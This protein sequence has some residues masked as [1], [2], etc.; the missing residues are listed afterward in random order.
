MI[1]CKNNKTAN[2][3]I[4]LAAHTLAGKKLDE[5]PYSDEEM[6]AVYEYAK[7]AD[8]GGITY[9]AIENA[10]DEEKTFDKESFY[11][12]WKRLRL[13]SYRRNLL[14]D[15]EQKKILNFFDE[16]G[17]WYMPLKGAVIKDFYPSPDLR[18]MNDIDILIDKTKREEINEYM[19][20]IG[21]SKWDHGYHD[22][23]ESVNGEITK[24]EN[25]DDYV[26]KPFYYFEMHKYLIEDSY[27]PYVAK[28][29]DQI[30]DIVVKDEGN[31]CGYHFKDN[32]FYIYLIAHAHKHFSANGIGIRF[33]M[34]VY[35]YLNSHQDLD[36]DYIV[37]FLD[38]AGISGFEKDVRDLC[39]MAFDV[40]SQVDIDDLSEPQRKLYDSVIGADTF[41]NIE[42]RWKNQV[43]TLG[44]G[45]DVSKFKYYK[46][47]LFPNEKWYRIYHP[48]VYK[49]KIV[50]PFFIIYR[51]TVMAF[52]G[53]KTV[54]REMEQIGGKDASV[55][56]D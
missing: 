33:L 56:R 8:I 53:R 22:D 36:L 21:Y 11:F 30:M 29:Y 17:I 24:G 41:G 45:E 43:Y 25:T 14:Y 39:Q 16:H 7:R 1:I 3:A 54:K 26:K 46:S 35:I 5:I 4:N 15:K 23:P 20:S 32:D 48:F 6:Q 49:H 38:K 55:K 13:N 47:R 37:E 18:E 27:S 31:K 50:K 12:E 9:V 34:D 40:D 10:L 42:T 51:M 2:I 44:S 52:R 28:H 19:T